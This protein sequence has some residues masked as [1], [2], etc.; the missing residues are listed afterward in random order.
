MPRYVSE[1]IDKHLADHGAG[2]E[3]YLFQVTVSTS[4]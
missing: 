2:S 4:S 1:A 3:G